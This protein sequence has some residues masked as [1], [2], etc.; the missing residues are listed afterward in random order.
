MALK[1]SKEE[2]GSGQTS[3]EHQA[4]LAPLAPFNN[5]RPFELAMLAVLLSKGGQADK[6]LPAAASLWANAFEY[7]EELRWLYWGLEQHEKLKAFDLPVYSI[8]KEPRLDLA[9]L[10]KLYPWGPKHWR[11]CLKEFL[12]PHL[13]E[14]WWNPPKCICIPQRVAE[15]VVERQEQKRADRSKK[16]VKE[17]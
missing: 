9:G 3:Q 17:N 15:A 13:F 4:T 11:Q 10:Q 7:L 14:Q 12:P 8:G 5:A 1:K 2:T 6:F 16:S